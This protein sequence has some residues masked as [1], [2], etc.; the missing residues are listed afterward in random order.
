MSSPEY[1]YVVT[2]E[3]TEPH[4]KGS[5]G[6]QTKDILGVYR[7]LAD[8]NGSARSYLFEWWDP[9]WFASYKEV[10]L[11]GY[12]QVTAYSKDEDQFEIRVAQQVLR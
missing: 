3:H 11:D 4:A 6:K 8:A 2:V 9:E 7:S 10:R 1:V 5:P 12:V